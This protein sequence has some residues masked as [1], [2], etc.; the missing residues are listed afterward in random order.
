M[1]CIHPPRA[2]GKPR[3]QKTDTEHT[4]L[5]FAEHFIQLGINNFKVI[6]TS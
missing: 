1:F 3:A 4:P 2:M 6:F 5:L